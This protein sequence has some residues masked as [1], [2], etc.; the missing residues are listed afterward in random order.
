MARISPVSISWFRP[1][2]ENARRVRA[3]LVQF[4]F[5]EPDIWLAG[6]TAPGKVIQSGYEPNR[7]TRVAGELDGL[8][9]FFIGRAALL[10]NKE[11]NS[12]R[13]MDRRRWFPAVLS[14]IRAK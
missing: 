11:S 8:A 3:A 7:E 5:G 9:V 12:G 13:G 10:R 14:D 1:A 6:L 2:P 4:G